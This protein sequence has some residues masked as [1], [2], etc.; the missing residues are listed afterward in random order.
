MGSVALGREL[1]GTLP[2]FLCWVILPHCR[3]H[4]SWVEHSPPH[5]ISL[6][7]SNSSHSLESLLPHPVKLEHC[8][9]VH[10]LA[11]AV[12]VWA[13]SGG[14]SDW[15]VWLW[16]K[17]HSFHFPVIWIAPLLHKRSASSTLCALSG[18]TLLTSGGWG[19]GRIWDSLSCVALGW[20]LLLP[21]SP[22]HYRRLSPMGDPLAPPCRLP[23]TRPCWDWAPSRI[24]DRVSCKALGE[25]PF[26]P[27][28]HDLI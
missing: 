20:G 24:L 7:K 28:T 13:D 5:G 6:E 19:L 3:Y 22:K 15:V 4:H 10:C 9:G 17:D 12:Q 2:Q 27:H 14:V 21:H 11:Q 18:P 23:A 26:S 1:R 16:G 8:W 25:E